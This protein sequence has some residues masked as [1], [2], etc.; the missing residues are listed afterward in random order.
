MKTET[1]EVNGKAG[2]LIP[3]A[4]NREYS[5][6][7]TL[8]EALEM[9]GEAGI[10]GPYLIKRKTNFMDKERM[11]IEKKYLAKMNTKEGKELLAEL[12]GL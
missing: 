11:A 5:F 9:D 7:E 8:E 10:M 12:L 1:I 4:E 2:K 6:P 3:F